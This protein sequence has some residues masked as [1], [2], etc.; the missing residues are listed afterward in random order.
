[1]PTSTSNELALLGGPPTVTEEQPE[2]FRWPRFG[3]EHEAA[4]I[5]T[6]RGHQLSASDI[7]QRFE[8]DWAA[9]NG[10]R[11]ALSYPNGTMALQAAIFAAGLGRGD[12]LICTPITFWGSC[13]Q[14]YQL[15]A[16]PVFADI[17]PDT[18]CIDPADIERHISPRTKAIMA[19][20]YAGHP[21]DMDA[22]MAIARAHD[23]VV[24]EDV[25]H[26]HG[27]R[28][29]G[30]ML[31]SI[32]HLAAMSMMSGKAFAIGEGGMLVSDDERYYERALAFSHYSRVAQLRDPEL[33]AA[34]VDESIPHAA[35]ICNLGGVKGRLNQ[36]SSAI[37]RVQLRQYPAV[38]QQIQ[39][40]MNR[41]WDAMDG[42]PG[43]RAHRTPPGGDSSMGG[44]YNPIG[45]YR[46][47]ELGGLPV[48]RFAEA[49]NAEGGRCGRSANF[50]L[51]LHPVFNSVDIYGDGK[52][53]RI[54][55]ADRDLR[56][57]RGSL[58]VAEALHARSIGVPGF[59][60]D[61]PLIDRYAEAYRKV[62]LQHA[63]L[64]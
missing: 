56:Q 16:T 23:L 33:R 29:R 49:V 9:Y 35:P 21:C 48:E 64:T 11:H 17:D 47:E 61:S 13:Q 28:Y 34:C 37:G 30:R 27:G 38:M 57:A 12:E 59:R 42:V 10:V 32:G 52:P 50:A 25:S 7:S 45:H 20:H 8:Q 53:T 54:A 40:A 3:P 43:I 1:M 6:L 24:I 41:F 5:A 39:D 19:V 51:H 31:G 58:P 22:I 62:A 26:A 15:G 60:I 46:P 14:C 36:L 4:V 18:L 55:F 63:Q 44:W 2:L